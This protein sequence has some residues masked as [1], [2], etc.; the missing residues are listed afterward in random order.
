MLLYLPMLR[1]GQ[2]VA[3]FIPIIRPSEMHLL[4]PTPY[5]EMLSP[6]SSLIINRFGEFHYQFLKINDIT[7]FVIVTYPIT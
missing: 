6:L 3:D 1:L 7:S 5:L 2:T 4:R